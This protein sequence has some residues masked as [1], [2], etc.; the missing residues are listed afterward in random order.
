MSFVEIAW[1]HVRGQFTYHGEARI[2]GTRAGLAEL[3]TAIGIALAN[4]TAD[5]FV[6]AAD[7]EGYAVKVVRS[8]T[9]S[10]LGAPPYI[11]ELAREVAVLERDWVK[12]REAERDRCFDQPR[13][14]T[15]TGVP[16]TRKRP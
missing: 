7:G 8:S 5:A 14:S 15:A 10:G 3:Q 16:L 4:G 11:D 6:A 1:L 12:Q 9:V 2:V 13:R